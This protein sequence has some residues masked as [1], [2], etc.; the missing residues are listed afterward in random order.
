V[1]SACQTVRCH[2]VDEHNMNLFFSSKIS[3]FLYSLHLNTRPFYKMFNLQSMHSRRPSCLGGTGA[4]KI[5]N[6][7]SQKCAKFMYANL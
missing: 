5:N 6:I 3:N 4:G 7:G 1:V 2:E